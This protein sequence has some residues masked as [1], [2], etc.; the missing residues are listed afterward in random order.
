[1]WL[2]RAEENDCRGLNTALSRRIF[3]V[4]FLILGEIVVLKAGF[5]SMSN[6]SWNSHCWAVSHEESHNQDSS[7]RESESQQGDVRCS[8]GGRG[9]EDRAGGR[10]GAWPQPDLGEVKTPLSLSLP[11]IVGPEV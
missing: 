7:R 11:S 3:S 6:H 5:L 4:V 2:V 1:M 9:A 10:A 8:R